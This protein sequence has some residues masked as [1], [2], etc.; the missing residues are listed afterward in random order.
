MGQFFKMLF[1]SFLGVCIAICLFILIGF[2][3]L[4]G[5]IASMD[6]S[7]AA[8][9]PNGNDKVLELSLDGSLNDVANESPFANIF[10]SDK[11]LSLK[12]LQTAI[13]VAKENKNIKGIY[14]DASGL[15]A[16]VA[17]IDALRRS[18]SD[19]KESGKFIV[20]YG[21]SYTQ[22]CYYLSSVADK[23]FVNPQGAINLHG[24]SSD[25]TFYKGI[26]KKA[27]IEM[28]VFKVGTFKG[29]VEPFMLDKLSDANRE[30]ITSYQQSIWTNMVNNIASAR[31]LTPD[32]VNGFI[33]NGM[34]LAAA[35]KAVELGFVDGVKYRH[36][37]EDYVKELAGIDADKKLKTVGPDKLKRAKK[38]PAKSKAD[39]IAVVYAEGDIV[40]SQTA[41]MYGSGNFITEN[42]AEKLADLKKDK[43]VKAVVLRVNSPGGSGFVSEQIWK[44]VKDLRNEKKIVVSMGNYAASGGYYISCAA[45]K[46]ISE[47]N[48]LTGSIGVFSLYPDIS[49]LWNKLDLTSDVVK[50]NK[51]S[52]MGDM[53]RPMRDDEKALIQSAVE[54]FYDTFL[55]RCSDG[56][57]MSKE[58]I[59]TIAQG[60]VW[61]GEQALSIGLVDEIGDLKRAIEVAAELAGLTD[62]SV[63]SVAG[64]DDPIS[65]YIKKQLGDVKSSVIEDALGEDTEIFNTIRML[66]HT[67]GIQARMPYHL[68]NI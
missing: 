38:T 40:D 25:V 7:S 36:E 23:I 62:Y 12:D 29:A 3:V 50:T 33:D 27:G 28:L 21:D 17:N 18:L 48:T 22:G 19:F 66:K 59:D 58:D 14:I 32:D 15:S 8:Y 5:I 9:V 49:G 53:S 47:A 43:K 42:L 55:T 61:T 37:A 63:K 46:I 39:R 65:D 20:A 13:D 54:R 31:N 52:D 64:S 26:L 51:Y 60:R 10:S 1:A 4:A 56:R 16:G 2:V 6:S 67:R 45:D 34:M 24:L 44:Q 35:E 68:D 41:S 30:Q 57:G 11:A